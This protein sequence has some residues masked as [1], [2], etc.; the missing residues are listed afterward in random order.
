MPPFGPYH[1]MVGPIY[2]S[3]LHPATVIGMRVQEKH[4]NRAK[5]A[6]MH[7]GMVATLIDTAFTWAGKQSQEPP[8]RLLTTNLSVNLIGNASPGDWVE[9]HVDVVKSGRR[10]VFAD[11]FVWCKD[12][13]IAQA[14]GQMAVMGLAADDS[15]T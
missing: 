4:R 13:R 5:A 9:A 7:G 12:R 8:I 15:P 1:E 10:I 2:Y 14:S 6:M 3:L 11:C